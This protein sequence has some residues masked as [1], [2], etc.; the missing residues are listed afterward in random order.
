MYFSC[1]RVTNLHL[2]PSDLKY[3]SES[4]G[5]DSDVSSLRRIHSLLTLLTTWRVHLKSDGL[6]NT[7]IL[8]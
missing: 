8:V 1:D 3:K 2:N 5:L 6:R 7:H 4:D